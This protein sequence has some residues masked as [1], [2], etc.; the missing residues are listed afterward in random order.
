MINEYL[1][2]LTFTEEHTVV[3]MLQLLYK[4]VNLTA[5]QLDTASS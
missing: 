4:G 1:V 3:Y 2:Y 5:K